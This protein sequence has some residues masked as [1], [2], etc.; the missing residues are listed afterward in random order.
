MATETNKETHI[1]THTNLSPD[2][3]SETALDANNEADSDESSDEQLVNVCFDIAETE[4]EGTSGEWNK[5]M[6]YNGDFN[7]GTPL[8]NGNLLQKT[9]CKKAKPKDIMIIQYLSNRDAVG[10]SFF[11]QHIICQ[12]CNNN[13]VIIHV[14]YHVSHTVF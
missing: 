5:L 12:I 2:A 4:A 3:V 11:I 6:L 14:T 10:C 8:Y 13:Y 9:T 1:E 7:N